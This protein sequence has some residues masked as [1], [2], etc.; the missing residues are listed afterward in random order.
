MSTRHYIR[1]V[2]W[3]FY[4][5]QSFIVFVLHFVYTQ[6]TYIQTVFKYNFPKGTEKRSLCLY[7]IVTPEFYMIHFTIVVSDLSTTTMAALY[8]YI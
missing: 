5:K 1:S 3:H 6:L 7:N 2:L 4:P 8:V